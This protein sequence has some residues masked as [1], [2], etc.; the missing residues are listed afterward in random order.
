ML[1]VLKRLRYFMQRDVA[2]LNIVLCI[3]LRSIAQSLPAHNPGAANVNKA[4][5]HIVAVAFVHRFGHNLNGHVHFHVC[6]VDGVFEK[7][8]GDLCTSR[9]CRSCP[10][11]PAPLTK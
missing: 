3:F 9:N 10:T 11:A 2:V 5:Q 1:S 4:A 7:L 6:I 8:L